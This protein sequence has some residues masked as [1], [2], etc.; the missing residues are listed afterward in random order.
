MHLH[1]TLRCAGRLHVD[2]EEFFILRKAAWYSDAFL[3]PFLDPQ[4]SASFA[5]WQLSHINPKRHELAFR[6]SLLYEALSRVLGGNSNWLAEWTQ[7][8]W[9]LRH[10]SDPS[11][12]E[13]QMLA[14]KNQYPAFQSATMD[15]CDLQHIDFKQAFHCPHGMRHCSMDGILVS[16]HVRDT[17]FV[18]PWGPDP[19]AEIAFGSTHTSRVLVPSK[20]LRDALRTFAKVGLSPGE[21]QGL[22]DSL[23]ASKYERERDLGQ[24]LALS[25]LCNASQL[26]VVHADVR[27]L[28]PP[29]VYVFVCLAGIVVGMV[30]CSFPAALTLPRSSFRIRVHLH[31]SPTS[32]FVVDEERWS[33]V[34][35]TSLT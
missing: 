21:L 2:G 23:S 5:P 12:L 4:S 27:Y 28:S 9:N 8:C 15:F 16:C 7:I 10:H 17:H 18:R 19:D 35:T 29:C 11:P 6:W 22:L 24:L 33:L 34:I 14:L 31:R 30:C 3:A 13:S 26:C 32:P 25:Y 1:G 20:K